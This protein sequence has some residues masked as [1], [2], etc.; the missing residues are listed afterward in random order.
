M[1]QTLLSPPFVRKLIVGEVKQLSQS[2]TAGN[3]R[4]R[5][6]TQSLRALHHCVTSFLHVSCP[7]A[8]GHACRLHT[9]TPARDPLISTSFLRAHN[10]HVCPPLGFGVQTRTLT[11]ALR[12]KYGLYW[13]TCKTPHLH[14]ARKETSTHKHARHTKARVNTHKL[15]CI[16]MQTHP[17][18]KVRAHTHTCTPHGHTWEYLPT[19]ML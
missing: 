5:P 7:G 2:H 11:G 12:Y 4:A 3:G 15:C 9:R 8:R 16:C 14:A 18:R 6:Q 17:P 1:R 13:Q 19:H 10:T